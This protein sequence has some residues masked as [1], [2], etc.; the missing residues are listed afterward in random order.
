MLSVIIPTL[1]AESRL[2]EALAALVPATVEGLVREVVVV[3]AGSSDAT[4][5]IADQAGARLYR[6][7][8]G[9]GYQLM[10]GAQKARFPWLLFLH[11]DTV[12]QAGWERDAAAFMEAVDAGRRPRAA[13][14]FRFALDDDGVMPRLLERV[15]AL[16]CGLFRLPYGD[17]GLLI[18][19][20][21]YEEIGG[22]R[23]LPLMDDVDLVRR[24]GPRRTVLLRTPAVT[25]AARYRNDGYVRRSARN[26]SCLLLYFLGVPPA[27][28]QRLYS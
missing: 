18:P 13:A 14:A 11:G 15:V 16:R 20:A 1:N 8:G 3:D 2:V 28:I 6:R 10:F 23:S 12:L 26:A 21:L 17:Q 7:S 9:R 19:K 24:L 5:T 27:A 25:S 22:H 4:A